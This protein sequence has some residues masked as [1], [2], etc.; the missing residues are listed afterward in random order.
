MLEHQLGLV[1]HLLGVT[2]VIRL[3]QTREGIASRRSS[4]RAETSR[5]WAGGAGAIASDTWA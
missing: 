1:F 2:N 5:A 4:R 3:V